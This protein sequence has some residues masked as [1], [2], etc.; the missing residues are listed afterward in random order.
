MKK[1][2]IIAHEKKYPPLSKTDK[3]L[4][5]LILL[6][7]V[8][9]ITLSTVVLVKRLS[10]SFFEKGAV[11]ANV[12]TFPLWVNSYLPLL[13]IVTIA[14]LA[15]LISERSQPVF[16][17]QSVNYYDTSKYAFTL[18]L[19]DRRYKNVKSGTTMKRKRQA[20]A[21]GLLTVIVLIMLVVSFESVFGR[22][23]FTAD[24]IEKHSITGSMSYDYND[25]SEYNLKSYIE[26]SYSRYGRSEPTIAINITMKNGYR[27]KATF[28]DFNY[29][30]DC[31]EAVTDKLGT[32]QNIDDEYLSDFLNYHDFTDSEK[33]TIQKLFAK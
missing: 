32:I 5:Y 4:Y 27:I 20:V 11:L 7:D 12:P 18:P 13:S 22:I 15:W 30:I 3:I 26:P 16:G 33:E 9:S 29:D 10:A 21:S 24:S 2:N 17:N 25:V 8:W 1:K 19:F 23:E 31:L 28:R 6:A 14:Y